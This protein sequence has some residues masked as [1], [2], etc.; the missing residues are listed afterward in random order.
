MFVEVE[1]LKLILPCKDCGRPVTESETIAY[2]LV[3][4]VFC[5]WCDRCFN[6]RGTQTKP[7]TTEDP[8][9]QNHFCF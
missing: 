7:S 9:C 8:T 6:S 3:A 1:S 2:R 5:G 4:G